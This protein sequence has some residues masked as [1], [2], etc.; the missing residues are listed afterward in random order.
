M[1]RVQQGDDND[2]H[3]IKWSTAS[4]TPSLKLELLTVWGSEAVGAEQTK[5]EMFAHI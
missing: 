2:A 5:V 3:V 4:V 1:N